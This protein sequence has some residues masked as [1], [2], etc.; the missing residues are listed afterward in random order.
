[1]DA[2]KKYSDDVEEND[3]KLIADMHAKDN[4]VPGYCWWFLKRNKHHLVI[5][6]GHKYALCCK[7]WS[8]YRNMYKMYNE[9]YVD[10]K[11]LGVDIELENLIW[12]GKDGNRVKQIQVAG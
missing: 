8:N 1:M 11:K 12:F 2:I 5:K 10:M 4:L 6:K 3:E 9:I 7:D